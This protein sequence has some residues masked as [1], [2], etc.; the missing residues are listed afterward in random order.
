[1]SEIEEKEVDSNNE[2][3]DIVHPIM[4]VVIAVGWGLLAVAVAF[5]LDGELDT[6][7]LKWIVLGVVVA[8]LVWGIL[9]LVDRLED[10]RIPKPLPKFKK[11]GVTMSE[12]EEKEVLEE[13]VDPNKKKREI[14]ASIIITVLLGVVF[15]FGAGS[16][17]W[18]NDESD[19]V[20][21]KMSGVGFFVGILFGGILCSVD[22]FGDK[23]LPKWLPQEGVVFGVS[24]GFVAG[25]VAW[26]DGESVAVI[27]KWSGVG[28]VA[29]FLLGWLFYFVG[30]FADKWPNIFKHIRRA[31]VAVIL[32]SLAVLFAWMFGESDTIPLKWVAVGVGVALLVWG[33]DYLV[34]KIDDKRMHKPLP[35]D[36]VVIM[37]ESK[38]VSKQVGHEVG[39]GVVNKAIKSV[40]VIIGVTMV[41][42]VIAWVTAFAFEDSYIVFDIWWVVGIVLIGGTVS[43]LIKKRGDRFVDK[44]LDKVVDKIIDDTKIDQKVVNWDVAKVAKMV[45][46]EVGKKVV[47]IA[48]IPTWI[49]IAISAVVFLGIVPPL[50]DYW[51]YLSTF[52][53]GVLIVA[54]IAIYYVVID[55][56]DNNCAEVVAEVVDNVL[57]NFAG[58]TNEINNE[59]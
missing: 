59:G 11:G 35:K 48:R 1:M 26:A 15:A 7:P 36:N 14:V 2:K 10:K 5:L 42:L 49:V 33:I 9:P 46:K 31:V 12:L 28:L 38:D 51:F 30:W 41:A 3:R 50:D 53:D 19:A 21:L 58:S 52:F 56:F 44:D 24:L 25:V 20:I 34:D 27:L 47:K 39:K 8:L 54:I 6:V 18:S 23:W 17:A 32:G 40:R 45:G 57:D 16:D 22:F 55:V 13:E 43:Q 29:G 4:R 37:V